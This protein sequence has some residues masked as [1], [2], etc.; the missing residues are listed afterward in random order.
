MFILLM[1]DNVGI[2]F[3]SS[4]ADCFIVFSFELEFWFWMVL[5]LV[6]GCMIFS[7]SPQW[8][9]ECSL[10]LQPVIPP[11]FDVMQVSL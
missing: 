7:R 4:G 3:A 10:D 2:L 11:G 6:S 1:E 5:H 8:S 9:K